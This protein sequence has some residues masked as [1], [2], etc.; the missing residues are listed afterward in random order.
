M[1]ICLSRPVHAI[2]TQFAVDSEQNAAQGSAHC[3]Y[4][5]CQEGLSTIVPYIRRQ[6]VRLTPED[7]HHLVRFRRVVVMPPGQ[8]A[9]NDKASFRDEQSLAGVRSLLFGSA[10]IVLDTSELSPGLGQEE[11]DILGQGGVPAIVGWRGQYSLSIMMHKVEVLQMQEKMTTI[12][13]LRFENGIGA[14]PVQSADIETKEEGEEET[15]GDAKVEAKNEEEEGA[16][17]PAAAP[18][19]GNGGMAACA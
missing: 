12:V 6:I 7:F 18:A 4:R 9:K 14:G 17:A 11:A 1:Y 10:L 15:G 16:E 19:D 13:Q 5:L 8:V 3:G 2:V